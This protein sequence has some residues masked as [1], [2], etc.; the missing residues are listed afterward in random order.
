MFGIFHKSILDLHKVKGNTP[1][2][3][4]DQKAGKRPPDWH[5]P[6]I[7]CSHVLPALTHKT[8]VQ[9][10]FYLWRKK[11]TAL[12]SDNIKKP[13]KMGKNSKKKLNSIQS[14]KTINRFFCAFIRTF[15]WVTIKSDYYGNK[16]MNNL[17][18][19]PDKLLPSRILRW[20]HAYEN[21][22]LNV[23]ARCSHGA[24]KVLRGFM[25]LIFTPKSF[26]RS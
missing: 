9:R 4:R 17:L 26:P 19:I 5:F 20:L 25:G 21:H 12:P 13:P 18:W 3:H 24:R 11:I 7:S 23:C 6:W 1:R 14:W 22:P 16:R 15:T 8:S 2:I 10:D